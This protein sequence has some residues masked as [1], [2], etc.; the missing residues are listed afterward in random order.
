MIIRDFAAALAATVK[1]DFCH[2][3]PEN[4]PPKLL[5]LKPPFFNGAMLPYIFLRKKLIYII[6]SLQE[7]QPPETTLRGSL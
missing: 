7:P 4:S 5:S 3:P 2:L 1:M 6:M